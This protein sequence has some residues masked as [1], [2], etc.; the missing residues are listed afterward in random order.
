MTA[1]RY[2]FTIE[3]GVKFSTVITWKDANGAL[4][5]LTGCTAEL[6]IKGIECDDP[7]LTISTTPD[8]NGNVLTLGGEDGTIAV[9]IKSA[10][11]SGISWSE[12]KYDLEVT[13]S[14]GEPVR[15]LQGT[16]SISPE[17]K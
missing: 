14:L 10:T 16:F 13:D 4:V 8:D 15:L 17:V 1:G 5:D 11:T 2:S 3:Q 6:K 12:A 7:L 9:L